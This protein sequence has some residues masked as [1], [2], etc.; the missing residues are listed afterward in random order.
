M[1]TREQFR[2]TLNLLE[3]SQKEFGLHL[4][5][6]QHTVRGYAAG[7]PVPMPVVILMKLLLGGALDL[8]TVDGVRRA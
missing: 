4:G 3:M 7:R 8:K 1:M 2:D 5:I 6:S